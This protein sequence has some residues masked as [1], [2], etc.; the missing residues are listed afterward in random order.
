MSDDAGRNDLCPCGSEKKMKVCHPN[1]Y[2]VPSKNRKVMIIGIGV[3]VV[4]IAAVAMLREDQAPP[5]QSA[6]TRP[7][8]PPAPGSP[9]GNTARPLTQGANTQQPPGQ[10]PPGKVWSAEHGH[11]HDAPGGAGAANPAT[12]VTPGQ[13]QMIQ[14]PAGQNAN[15]QP[16]ANTPEPPGPAPEGKVWDAGHG[17]YHDA[18]KT[19]PAP[20][21]APGAG[22]N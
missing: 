13:P 8:T 18:P 5:V 3:A 11:Y 6:Q 7:M 14:I 2:A 10:A 4:A 17:H 1:G 20:A 22:P 15:Q 16:K 21:P 12:Q 9:A 19:A